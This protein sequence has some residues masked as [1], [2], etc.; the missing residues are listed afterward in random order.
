MFLFGR[1][2]AVIIQYYKTRNQ[3]Y[4]IACFR[5]WAKNIPHWLGTCLVPF[6]L[7]LVFPTKPNNLFKHPKNAAFV[8][9]A[10]KTAW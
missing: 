9:T 1:I 5:L 4:L 2:K 7:Y 8:T 10:E 3:E 6:K